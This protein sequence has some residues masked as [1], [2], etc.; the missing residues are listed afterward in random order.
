[1]KQEWQWRI[2]PW[3]LAS[4]ALLLT[5][6]IAGAVIAQGS[7][8]IA[9]AGA[10]DAMAQSYQLAS[11]RWLTQL[12]GV[13]QRTFVVLAAIEFAISGLLWGL[14]R[15]SLDDIAGRFL[16][17]F[18]LVAFLLLLITSFTTWVTPI[19]DG[20]AVAGE[21]AIGGMTVSPSRVID[22]GMALGDH[23]A[24]TFDRWGVITHF[25]MAIISGF[26]VL[27]ILLAYIVIATQLVLTL[28]ES[29]IVL[30]G[31]VLFLGFTAFRATAAYGENFL[32]YAVSVGI[33]IFLL[34]LIVGVGTSVTSSIIR[35]MQAEPEFSTNLAPLGQIL[36][37]AIIF[38]VMAV[39]IP[40]HVAAR[41]TATHSFG[42]ANALR[43][44]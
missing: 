30:G 36:G 40:N 39:R 18:V 37:L 23:V 28:V 4:G 2:P 27:I 43:S 7:A 10:L 5:G 17:K 41:I 31:G 15:D 9:P 38:A 6:V 14:R 29:Y 8:P 3:A 33:K 26:A 22:L 1:M 35:V 13:A 19:V 12:T 32:N 20:F 34:Y 42:V 24:K 25:M 11:Q 21:R 44:L 16:L